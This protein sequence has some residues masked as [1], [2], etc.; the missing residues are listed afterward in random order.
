MVSKTFPTLVYVGLSS[1]N[2]IFWR[3]R[4]F[5]GEN[6]PPK[7]AS[8]FLKLRMPKEWEELLMEPKLF[9]PSPRKL[10]PQ[11]EDQWSPRSRLSQVRGPKT[12]AVGKDSPELGGST[13]VRDQPRNVALRLPTTGYNTL[14]SSR[15]IKHGIHYCHL[16]IQH[17]G[18][19]TK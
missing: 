8:D 15:I 19:L 3:E 18:W 12:H 7:E 5:L 6:D 9:R 1:K 14:A 2:A 16:P 10:R 13:G 17:F 11:S 4:V